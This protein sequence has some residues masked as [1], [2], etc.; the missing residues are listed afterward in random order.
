M[1]YSI[2]SAVYKITLDKHR[3]R[4]EVII[5]GRVISGEPDL[6][7]LFGSELVIE[8]L[9]VVSGGSLLC[10]REHSNKIF[11]LPDGNKDF[12]ISFSFSTAV[13]EDN[14]SRFVSIAVPQA[15]KNSLSL[16][17]APEISL[18][19]APGIKNSDTTYHFSARAMLTIRFSD[20]AAV[21]A[22]PVVEIDT[23]SV[24]RLHGNQ[25]I[26][27]TTFVPVQPLAT[28]FNL[29]IQANTTYVSST[30]KSSWIKKRDEQSY[31]INL[32][33]GSTDKFSIQISVDESQTAGS[34]GFFLPGISGNTGS[35]GNFI[36]EQPDGGQI[37]LSGHKLISR[38]PVSRLNSKLL[39]AVGRH[40]FFMKIAPQDK[41]SL[42]VR[43]FQTVSTAPVVLD[44][45]SFF[46]SFDDNGSVL[47]V[48]IMD[49]PPEVGPRL[50]M[51]AIPR[52]EIWSLKVN[53]QKTNVYSERDDVST[54][55][56][57]ER[58]IIPLARGESSHV[59][60][61]FIRQDQK[62]GLQGKFETELPAAGL[63]SNSVR[64]GIALS[65]RL[66]LLSLEGPVSPA[67]EN[68]WQ[69]PKEFIGRPYYF[70][71]TFYAGDGLKMMLSYKE[72][73][74]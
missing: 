73:V 40:R 63:P 33:P 44:S 49:I 22:A 43:R 1:R 66:Q 51:Q 20:K 12:Q 9:T 25:A 24:I 54:N 19:E 11:F 57:A 6:I 15:L 28:G 30:L 2:A 41:I 17:L 61:A 74:N 69:K 65:E 18:V 59:E 16:K 4:G 39:A 68:H 21:S 45:I 35:Q 56:G 71:R 67:P 31:R 46:T 58:W 72:P 47:S 70:T 53:G 64:I 14:S 50:S 60:L 13:K 26:I 38:I 34:Y 55:G 32:P 48:L 52:A 3:A 5:A 42:S 7:P 23:L 27:T 36:T 62:P 29:L 37:S 10:A 8:D